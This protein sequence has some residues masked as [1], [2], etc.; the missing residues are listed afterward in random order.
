M[1]F[2]PFGFFRTYVIQ[3]IRA[4]SLYWGDSHCKHRLHLELRR[5]RPIRGEARQKRASVKNL[6]EKMGL[7]SVSTRRAPRA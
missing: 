6:D 1:D 2:D 7:V 4:K 3:P 5:R